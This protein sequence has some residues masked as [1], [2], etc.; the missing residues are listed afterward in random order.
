MTNEE[1]S[2]RGVILKSR[3]TLVVVVAALVAVA[4]V[5]F[6]MTRGDD[7]TSPKADQSPSKSSPTGSP[8]SDAPTTTADPPDPTSGPTSVATIP[9]RKAV[10]LDERASFGD[11]VTAR[12]TSVRAVKGKGRGAGEISGPALKL[13][14]R[15]SN[16]T[17]RAIS[18]DQVTVN[19]AYGKSERPAAPL[20]GDP[21][22]KQFDGRLARGKSKRGTYVFNVPRGGRG[23][24]EIQIN[25]AALSPIVVFAGS[26]N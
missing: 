13:N 8:G 10:T 5:V 21:A 17:K 12:I 9:T 4:L 6:F 16:G 7:G 2:A 24:I 23:R 25:H 19:M 14:I 11:G 1:D 15:L 22:A 20:L 3:R 26:A 18:L